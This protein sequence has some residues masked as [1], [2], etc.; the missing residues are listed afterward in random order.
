MTKTD[1]KQPSPTPR[2]TPKPPATGPL[3]NIYTTPVPDTHPP[4]DLAVVEIFR[5][6]CLDEFI[7]HVIAET[8]S[9][10]QPIP[11][12]HFSLQDFEEH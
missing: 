11:L 10:L 2:P 1:H 8:T 5:Y 4:L 7:N 6:F 9:R 12:S 3:C